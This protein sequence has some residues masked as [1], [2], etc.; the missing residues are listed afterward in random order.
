MARSSFPDGRRTTM[1]TSAIRSGAPTGSNAT[2]SSATSRSSGGPLEVTPEA[3][4]HAVVLRFAE[5]VG[6]GPVTVEL[7]FAGPIR[8]D[9]KALYR[10]TRGDER[11]AITTLWPAESRR[12]F[13]CFDEPSFKARFALELT[14]PHGLVAIANARLLETSDDGGGRTRW[15]FGETPPLSPYLLAFA[16]GPFEGTEDVSTTTG[17][18]LRICLPRGPAADGVH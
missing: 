17:T 15:R 5:P 10:S 18:P 13:P 3:A 7:D 2:S 16:V 14:A 6:P 9:L 4:A 8:P 1:Q 12:L 11:Y